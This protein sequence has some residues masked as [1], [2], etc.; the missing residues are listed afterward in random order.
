MR[1]RIVRRGYSMPELRLRR[2]QPQRNKNQQFFVG[3]TRGGKSAYD[4]Q[5][6]RFGNIR[7]CYFYYLR[8]NTRYGVCGNF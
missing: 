2:K 3:F 4:N 7:Y 5:L 6:L 8:N 1:K